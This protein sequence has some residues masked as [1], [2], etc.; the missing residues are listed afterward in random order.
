MYVT[1]SEIIEPVGEGAART[2]NTAG[3]ILTPA[4]VEKVK[5]LLEREGRDDL[6]LRVA[7]QPGGCSG[8]RYQ[9]VFDDRLFDG[10]QVT[11]FGDAEEPASE[12]HSGHDSGYE[13]GPDE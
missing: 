4:A 12:P 7:V 8:L 3:V 6:R 2:E 9:L 10:D 1:T 13:S 11:R 5:A